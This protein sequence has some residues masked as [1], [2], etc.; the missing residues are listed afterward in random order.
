[1]V[2]EYGR[3]RILPHRF[4]QRQ[5][6]G[7]IDE[8]LVADYGL[9]K[10]LKYSRPFRPEVDAVAVLPDSLVLIEAKIFKI[11]DGMA[12]LPLYASLVPH[13]PELK[14][15]L[16]RSIIMRLVVPWTSDN[17]IIMAKSAGV[18]IDLFCPEWVESEVE[19]Q[20]RYWTAD[21]RRQRDEKNRMIRY[22]GLE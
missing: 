1:M 10:A 8:R 14:E 16:P 20:H 15:Y 5:P 4:I 13:T 11:I 22:F 17:L 6:L 19:R 21:Y 12:K 2:A 7:K 9:A 3:D 18:E